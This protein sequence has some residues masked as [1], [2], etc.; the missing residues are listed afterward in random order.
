MGDEETQ[1]RTVARAVDL[2]LALQH[3]PTSLAKLSD[4]TGLTKPTAHRLLA[5][6]AHG[7]LVIQDP[8][9]SDYMLG[10]GCFGIA[11]AVLR[12]LGGLGIL[13]RPTLARLSA[14][15]QESVALH[16]SAGMQRICVEQVPSPQPVRYIARVG[17]ANPLHTGSM[18]KVLLA[19]ADPAELSALLAKLPLTPVTEATI[20]DRA[21]LEAELA[22]IRR[23]GY[24]TSRGEQA[25][26][27]AAM[28][29]PIFAP[30]GRIIAALSV[31]GPME[32]LPDEIMRRFRPMLIDAG[33]EISDNLAA[34]A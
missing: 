27:V 7:Q 22:L 19:F 2:L 29:V 20:T 13:A 32:R 25:A 28:S 11:D 6:L 31:L 5:T 33:R 8:V 17:A 1:V 34:I 24:A 12:G 4:H 10:P 15:T 23:K 9:S 21:V 14:D 26:G 16:V 18:G 3:G 30:N